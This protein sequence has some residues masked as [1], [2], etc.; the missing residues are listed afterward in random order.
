LS[1]L[2]QSSLFTSFLIV[3]GFAFRYY[4]VHK[5]GVDINII[6]IA[7][8]VVVASLIG[9][10]GFYFGQL[11]IQKTIPVNYLAFSALFVFFMSHNLSNLLGLY[12]LSWFA[13]LAVVCFLAFFSAI[14][15]PRMISNK[16]SSE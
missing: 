8:S 5:S 14:R 10:V 7:L 12:Q 2:K 9:G 11:K 1:I 6:A 13:Y 15:V 3:F 16:K 4:A